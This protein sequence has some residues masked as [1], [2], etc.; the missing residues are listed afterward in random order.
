MRRADNINQ[1]LQRQPVQ[2]RTVAGGAKTQTGGNS[3]ASKQM[4]DP[5][6]TSVQIPSE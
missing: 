1:K 5:D 6:D 3:N 2:Q 4:N